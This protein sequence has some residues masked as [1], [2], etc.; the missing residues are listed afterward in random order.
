MGK[1]ETLQPISIKT[2]SPKGV[3]LWH[4][5]GAGCVF[6]SNHGSYGVSPIGDYVQ[7]ALKGNSKDGFKVYVE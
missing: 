6:T 2:N 4:G 5:A 3:F 1:K 7:C